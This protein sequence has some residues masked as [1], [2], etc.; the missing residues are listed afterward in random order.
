MHQISLKQKLALEIFRKY[1]KTEARLHNLNYLFWEC[2][3]RCNI[4]CLH[5]GSDCKHEA[6]TPDMPLNHF[7]QALDNITPIVEPNKT[8]IVLTGGEPLLRSDLEEC[9]K[10]FYE[11]GFPWGFVSNGIALTPK[12]L[13]GLMKSG[14]RAATISFDGM[15]QSHNWFRNTPIGYKK[16]KEAIHMIA[17]QDIDFDTVTCANQRNFGE[18]HQIKNELLRMGVKRWRIFTITPIGRAKQNPE[19]QL[20]ALQFKQLF[21]FIENVRK[22]GDI[23]L[24]YGCEGYLGAYEGKVRDNMFFCRAGI[25]I[26]S[27]L[28]DGSISACPNLRSNYIQGN[29][30]RDSFRDVWE[31]RYRNMRNRSWTETGICAN[32]KSYKYCEG[33]GLHLHNED[34]NEVLFCHLNK[35]NQGACIEKLLN[36]SNTN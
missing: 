31:N 4:S 25:R 27:V 2:T 9:G 24:N 34:S 14:L 7:L 10:A 18:L 5:C 22:Q 36:S 19:L 23:S 30:Y 3:L 1:R 6:S 26:G 13:E 11:R 12:R 8:N 20:N 29:I 17:Q 15:E 35:I 32:C 28:A 16:A 21:D 33:S